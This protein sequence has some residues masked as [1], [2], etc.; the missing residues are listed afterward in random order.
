MYQIRTDLALETQEKMQEDHV[1]LKG[2]RFLEEKVDKNITVSTVVIETENGAKTMGKPKGTYI[3]IEAGNMDE[4]DE[5]YHREISVQLAKIIRQLIQEKNEELSV[6]VVGL[7]N[8]EV[9]PDALGPRVVDN[10]FITRHIVKEYGKYAFGEKNVN[11]ISSIVPGVMAQTG[12]E[13]WMVFALS[14]TFVTGSGQ[15]MICNLWL[16]GVPA[17][18]IVASVAAISS[19][20]ALYSA[21]IAP[22]LR[23][24]SKR[25][26]LAVAATLTEEAYGISL[27]K[28]VEGEDW[29]PRE[30]F[31]LNVILI[32]TWGVSCT[33]GAI[34]GAV[35]D[36]PTAIA[37]FVCTS[38]FICLLFSQRLSRGN[39]VA[40]GLAAVSV[41]ICKFLGWTNIAV[42]ASV[43]V[44]VVTA[45]ACDVLAE[46]RGARN[47]R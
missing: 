16:A 27:A 23:G 19:R 38:L 22:H 4:E 41:A 44:G 35:V 14:S 24:A 15:F 31:V 47:A 1:D 34:V 40:A 30:S 42:P 33:T 39:V 12:M 36:V 28:L 11:R 46:G 25:Q 9:T 3:T 13:P 43:L 32:A 26:T 18:S 29:G 5:D 7:G 8:R 2:V 37:G 10:L 21:S 17:A 45:L 20:F 6:L